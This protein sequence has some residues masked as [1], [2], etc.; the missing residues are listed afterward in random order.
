M[1]SFVEGADQRIPGM[2]RLG[3]FYSFVE[4]EF[5][6]GFG[7]GCASFVCLYSG[8][9]VGQLPTICDTILTNGG[10]LLFINMCDGPSPH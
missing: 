8:S 6:R 9:L 5:V 3:L 7:V 1:G 2:N 10:V 4:E